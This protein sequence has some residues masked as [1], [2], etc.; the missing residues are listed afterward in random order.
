VASIEF[1]PEGQGVDQDPGI[2]QIECLAQE[3]HVTGRGHQESSLRRRNVSQIYGTQ[4]APDPICVRKEAG[5]GLL[6]QPVNVACRQ[7]PVLVV[8]AGFADIVAIALAMLLAVS[9]VEVLSFG[10]EDPAS[11]W[12]D[13]TRARP[14]R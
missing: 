12:A 3:C 4:L 2:Q 11:Q 7:A 10:V 1:D 9:A 13:I 14:L 5:Q 6:N 8:L